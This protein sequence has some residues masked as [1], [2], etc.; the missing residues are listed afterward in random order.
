MPRLFV[1]IAGG[2]GSGKTTLAEGLRAALPLGQ[3]VVVPA[4]AYYRD[5]RHL[6]LDER[7]RRNFDEPAALD[8]ERLVAD[9]L[10]L[11]SGEGTRRP[12]YDF[13]THTRRP[14]QA[15]IPPRLVVIV[16]GILVLALPPLR[17]LFGLKVFV[18]AAEAVR[19]ER[20]IARDVGERGRTRESVIAQL[21]HI[22]LPMHEL[23]VA[24]SA[25]YADIVVSGEAAPATAVG[26]VMARIRRLTEPEERA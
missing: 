23:H 20:R 2:S 10:R 17:E 5:L 8:G 4:D 19:R 25:A 9:L 6:P 14:E 26:C 15:W 21:A 11:Q 12:V 18:A 22:T 24:P 3:A 13:S 7:Q 16:E 1:G